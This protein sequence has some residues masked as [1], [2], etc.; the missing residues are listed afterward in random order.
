MTK[1]SPRK[2]QIREI[3]VLDRKSPKT[4]RRR[5]G[6]VVAERRVWAYGYVCL[7]THMCMRMRMCMCVCI[8]MCMCMRVFVCVCVCVC[9][10]SDS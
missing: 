8:C 10:C 5:T 3:T 9:M 6:A 4:G 1:K 7:C 2:R